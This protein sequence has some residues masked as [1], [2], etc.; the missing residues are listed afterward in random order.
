MVMPPYFCEACLYIQASPSKHCKLCGWCCSKFDHHCLF[1]N[2]CVG[3]KNHRK[4]FLL[5]LATETAFIYYLTTVYPYLCDYN[6]HLDVKSMPLAQQGSLLYYAFADT[7]IN[8]MFV[9][10]FIDLFGIFMVF[11]LIYFQVRFISLGYTQQF[12]Q[13]GLFAIGNKRMDT[14]L[15]A[16]MHRMD[17]FHVFFFKSPEENEQLYY[18]QEQEFRNR[19]STSAIPLNNYPKANDTDEVVLQ[20]FLPNFDRNS[21]SRIARSTGHVH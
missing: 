14:L 12:P 21:I 8:W 7:R 1:I 10:I 3:L 15:K 9:M 16:F 13:S 5:I 19:A 2:K 4:F 6:I 17:N 18:R 20:D 11:F